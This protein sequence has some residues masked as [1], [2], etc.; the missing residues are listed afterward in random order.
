MLVTTYVHRTAGFLIFVWDA[1]SDGV[2]NAGFAKANQS[3]AACWVGLLYT[4]LTSDIGRLRSPGYH[5]HH[6]RTLLL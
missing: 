2:D 3:I 4:G 1:F 5:G 6:A